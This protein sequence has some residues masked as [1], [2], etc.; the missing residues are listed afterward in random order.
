MRVLFFDDNVNR[1]NSIV[2]KSSG[3]AIDWSRDVPETIKAIVEEENPYDV[4]CLDH[5][6]GGEML[7]CSDGCG[8]VV[9]KYLVTLPAKKAPTLAIVHS[10]NS[11]ASTR[12][13][14]YLD[15]QGVWQTVRAPFGSFWFK[16]REV[17]IGD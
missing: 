4:I 1:F 12:M 6:I 8:C 5:D 10:W 3:V 14:G 11:D 15:G 9:A 7:P 16:N 13:M 17:I 2:R